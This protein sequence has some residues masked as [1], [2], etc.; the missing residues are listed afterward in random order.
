MPITCAAICL[1]PTLLYPENQTVRSLFALL[2][3]VHALND[4]AQF[5]AASVGTAYYGWVYA[6]LDKA[7]EWT[8]QAGVPAGIARPLILETTR[9]AAAMGLARPDRDLPELLGL[10]AT[11]GGITRHGLK[12]LE[13]R[14]SF[15]A[16]VEAMD[17]VLERLSD[18]A[19]E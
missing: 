13:E 2:G 1:S 18:D 16:W 7:V 17:S 11:P 14:E 8:I 4:E 9:G 10:L 15:E 3:T 12:T 19:H 5:T 6:L